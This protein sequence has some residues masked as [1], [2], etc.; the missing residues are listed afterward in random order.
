M[1]FF[2]SWYKISVSIPQRWLAASGSNAKYVVSNSV[3]CV[4]SQTWQFPLGPDCRYCNNQ[5]Q[6]SQIL[7]PLNIM[8]TQLRDPLILHEHLGRMVQRVQEPP[9][10]FPLSCRDTWAYRTD[11]NF[12][13]ILML[14]H[15]THNLLFVVTWLTGS[16]RNISFI[17]F[18]DELVH[19]VTLW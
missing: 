14:S 16:W 9:S 5:L 6:P 7:E 15:K 18:I 17:A 13:F 2:Y 12:F 11:Y 1:I 4:L 8:G 19:H 3:I 10:I